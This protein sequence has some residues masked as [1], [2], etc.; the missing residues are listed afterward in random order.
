[1]DKSII[2]KVAARNVINSTGRVT[3]ES[4]GYRYNNDIYNNKIFYA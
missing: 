1:M 3:L 4:K 2:I